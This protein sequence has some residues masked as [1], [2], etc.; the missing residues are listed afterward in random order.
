MAWIVTNTHK[1]F[2]AVERNKTLQ[3]FKLIR[4]YRGVHCYHNNSEK[5]TFWYT[6]LIH[7]IQTQSKNKAVMEWLLLS[8]LSVILTRF[9]SLLY[10]W[11]C[12]LSYPFI[13]AKDSLSF[14]AFALWITSTIEAMQLVLLSH[15]SDSL[16]QC[17][18]EIHLALR[19]LVNQETWE[20]LI[21]VYH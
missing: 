20:Y 13:S 19:H 5:D 8:V 4:N 10:I 16:S 3:S 15:I 14:H 6:A 2:F 7:L 17:I 18:S 12:F 1:P 21:Q 11:K 9:Q